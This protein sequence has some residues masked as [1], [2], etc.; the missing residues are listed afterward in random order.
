MKAYCHSMSTPIGEFTFAVD[1]QGAVIGTAFGGLK[2]LA[3]RCRGAEFTEDSRRTASAAR[4]ISAYFKGGSHRLRIPVAPKGTP[5]QQ[6]VWQALL[7]IPYGE[8]RTYGEIAEMLQT[9]VR[10]VGGACGANPV[11]LLVPCHRVVGKNGNLTGF[12]FGVDL[13]HRLLELERAA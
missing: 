4:E 2:A 10:A 8:T 11:A 5:F 12:A 7:T 9:G 3:G 13:K 1:D 6:R